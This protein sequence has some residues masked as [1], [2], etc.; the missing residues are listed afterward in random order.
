MARPRPPL[1]CIAIGR[2][3]RSSFA[4]WKLRIKGEPLSDATVLF[5]ELLLI[6]KNVLTFLSGLVTCHDVELRT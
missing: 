6:V 3:V 5:I 4:L 2:I 1:R